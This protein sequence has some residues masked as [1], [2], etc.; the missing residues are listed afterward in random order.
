MILIDKP[1]VSDFLVKTIK[2]NNFPIIATNVAKTMISDESLNWIS[3]NEAMDFFKKN[4]T[5]LLYSN[6]ENAIS[7]IEKNLAFSKLPSQIQLFKNKIL[8]RELVKDIFPNYYFKGVKL[9]DL[10]TVNIEQ[11]KFPL[12]VKP[13]VGF[14]SLAVHK[15]DSIKEWNA[16]LNNIEQEIE[17]FKGMYPKEVVNVSDFIIEE[18]IE[19]DEYAIDCY[20]NE[21][22]KPVILNIMHH[23][24]SSAKDVSDRVYITSKEVIEKYKPQ[25]ETF[26]QH[27]GEKAALK[28]FPMHVEIRVDKT[29][30]INPIEINPL[31]FGGWCT[32]GDIS[33]FAYGFNSYEQYLNKKTPNWDEILK[34]RKDKKYNLIVLDNNSGIQETKIKTFNYNLLL[35]DFEKPLNLRKVNF[36]KYAVFGFLFTETSKNN[37][38]ETTAILASNLKKY[39][40]IKE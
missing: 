14:F 21:A 19:G 23:I 29:G 16:V 6:S 8:F 37:E 18:Y 10:N 7:W 36:K 31:R 12:I 17:T 4:P 40:T 9:T 1:F 32:T 38:F 15:V 28:N 33:Y 34:T 2:K 5:T 3:E 20:F 26:L 27:V 30:K 22:G 11:L 13:A 39:I 25:I 24:F 35:K